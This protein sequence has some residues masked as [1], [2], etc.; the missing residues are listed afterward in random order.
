VVSGE[1]VG[2]GAGRRRGD[3]GR[4]AGIANLGGKGNLGEVEGAARLL[5]A[6]GIAIVDAHEPAD[7]VL[8]NTCTVTSEADAKSRHAVRRARRTSPDAEIVVT[9]C[10]VQVGREAYAAV[11]PAARLVDNRSKDALL[12]EIADLV[13]VGESG[14]LPRALPTLSGVEIEGIVDGRA[15]VE[16]TRAFVKVQDGCS[17]FCTYCIIPAAR[18]P[19]RSHSP[20]T[21]LGDVR[22]ALRAGH[23]EIVLTGINIGTYDGGWSERGYRGSHRRSALTLAGLVR[24]I[25]AETSVE[26]I[27]LSSIEAQHV[28]DEL[29]RVWSDGAPRTLPHMHLPLQSGDDGVLRRMGRRYLSA[30]YADVVRRVRD[31]IPGAAVH[32]DAIVGFPTEDD[33][34]WRRSIDFIRSLELAGLHVFRYSQR[35]GTAAVRMRGHVDEAVKKHR[36][37]ELLAL[38]A[39]ARAAWAAAHVNT[40]ADVLFESRLANGRW[41]GHAADHTLVAAAPP[42]KASTS[43]ENHIGRVRVDGVDSATPDRVL[44]RILSLS[45]PSTGAAADA[46]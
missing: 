7:L 6:R 21:V 33:A 45:T 10:S 31:A 14:A 1:A 36:A 37:A 2:A 16:R 35:P 42:E 46:S 4:R 11:D 32:A 22:R 18:G 5:R 43:L 28:D 39:E 20:E 8:V 29:L 24:L 30:E 41:V 12:A 34:A 3:P 38:A 13:G 19:E 15:S 17:F 23:R 40:D 26:R 25:L 27:R 9:G 44:G